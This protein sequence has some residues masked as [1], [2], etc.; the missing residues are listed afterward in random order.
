[1]YNRQ[2]VVLLDEGWFM[3]Y[4]P[5][6]GK[7]LPKMGTR[8]CVSCGKPLKA[9]EGDEQGTT[10]FDPPSNNNPS[11]SGQREIEGTSESSQFTPELESKRRLN[12][13]QKKFII[14]VALAAVVIASYFAFLS[15]GQ[16]QQI[17]PSTDTSSYVSVA[18]TS[19]SPEKQITTAQKNGTLSQDY[20][21]IM[22]K[23]DADLIKKAKFS[24]PILLPSQIP[25]GTNCAAVNIENENSY[26]VTFVHS[27]CI[28]TGA[29]TSMANTVASM[30]GRLVGEPK[31]SQDIRPVGKDS[32]VDGPATDGVHDKQVKVGDSTGLYSLSMGYRADLAW[33]TNGVE[34]DLYGYYPVDKALEAANYLTAVNNS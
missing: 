21:N 17:P 5:H 11:Q 23:Y 24:F 33:C 19:S 25:S 16:D 13:L 10:K 14:S 7:K 31:C 12:L 4:C 1:M 26:L 15:Y 2:L 22:S 9:V 6:C 27:A 20:L 30:R 8:F 3:T 34:Y 32:N 29:D 18:P 28:G